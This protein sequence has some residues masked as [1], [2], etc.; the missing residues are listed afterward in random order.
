VL[1]AV[2][3]VQEL[4]RTP[5]LRILRGRREGRAER[6]VVVAALDPVAVDAFDVEEGA[7]EGKELFWRVV[8]SL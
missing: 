2:V 7:V 1:D 4:Q 6:V 3:R 8:C 5:R